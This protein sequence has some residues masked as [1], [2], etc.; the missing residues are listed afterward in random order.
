MLGKAYDAV[1][2]LEEEAYF[3]LLEKLLEKYVLPEAGEICFSQR[4]L[5]RMPEGFTGRI[6]TI[7]AE[8]GGSLTVSP[9][10]P[11]H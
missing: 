1:L 7:A 11:R 10:T 9:R 2:A 3:E 5:E 8:K 4:D 6:R